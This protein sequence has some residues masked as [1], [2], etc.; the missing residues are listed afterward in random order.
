MWVAPSGDVYL[1]GGIVWHGSGPPSGPPGVC[2]YE[3]GCVGM[4]VCHVDA[5]ASHWIFLQQPHLLHVGFAV[6]S[7]RDCH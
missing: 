2:V 5:S 6:S 7:T 3:G 4:S 1:Q